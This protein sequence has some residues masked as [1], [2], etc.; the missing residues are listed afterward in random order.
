MLPLQLTLA[1]L[2]DSNLPT[3]SFP[4]TGQGQFG[5]VTDCRATEI[6]VLLS[7]SPVV[8]R[9]FSQCNMSLRDSNLLAIVSLP[10]EGERFFSQKA[11]Q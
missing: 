7:V 5:S 10:W 3:V 9:V 4:R 6:S 1:K 11:P 8:E 2:C